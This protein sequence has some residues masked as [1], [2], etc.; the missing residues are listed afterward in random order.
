MSSS[1]ERAYCMGRRASWRAPRAPTRPRRRA[2]SDSNS[3]AKRGTTRSASTAP[4]SRPIA[5]AATS[6]GSMPRLPCSDRVRGAAY[7][8]SCQIPTPARM[9][10]ARSSPTRCASPRRPCLP[11]AR[12]TSASGLTD[13][14]SG[15][16]RAS[17]QP[18]AAAPDTSRARSPTFGSSRRPT[19][20]RG[21]ATLKPRSMPA[22]SHGPIRAA[23]ATRRIASINPIAVMWSAPAPRE[24]SSAVSIRRRSMSRPA[25]RTS[26]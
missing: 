16:T 2:R 1:A 4:A 26:A 10:R 18:S 5:G 6:K 8:R 24:R 15:M 19:S 13:T 23:G 14:R 7:W 22:A 25:T 3:S 9:T 11:T 17:R 12:R 21:P 20:T